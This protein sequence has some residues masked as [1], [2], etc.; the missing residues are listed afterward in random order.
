MDERLTTAFF[1]VVGV[2]ASLVGYIFLV[3]LLLRFVPQRRV[4]R[5]RPLL[6]IAP[7]VAFL[8][9]FLIYPTL[10]TIRRSFMD[11]LSEKYVGWDNYTYLWTDHAVRGAIVNNLLWLVF[12]TVGAV[13]IGLLVAVLVDRV[14]YRSEERRVGKECRSRW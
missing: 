8:A 14:R 9:V 5:I 13:G 10:D 12:L 7:A 1:V 2:P 3:E 6:W 11:R 4:P